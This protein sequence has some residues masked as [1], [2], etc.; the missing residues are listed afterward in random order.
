LL[1]YDYDGQ[2][3]EKNRDNPAKGRL[4]RRRF[5]IHQKKDQAKGSAEEEIPAI[6]VMTAFAFASSF[7]RLTPW[8]SEVRL[9]PL[10]RFLLLAALTYA[11]A[12]GP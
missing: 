10:L 9:Y 12:S 11:S 6:T 7:K 5:E 1:Q 4:L 2:C 8:C 3:I